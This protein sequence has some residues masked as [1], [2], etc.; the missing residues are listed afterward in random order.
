MRVTNHIS[1]SQ[2]FEQIIYF[3]SKYNAKYETAKNVL[4]RKVLDIHLRLS[5]ECFGVFHRSVLHS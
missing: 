5:S 1:I 4:K 3:L 2:F